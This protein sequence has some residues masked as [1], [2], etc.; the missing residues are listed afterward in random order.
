MVQNV[1]IGLIIVTVIIVIYGNIRKLA[2]VNLV[3]LSGIVVANLNQTAVLTLVLLELAVAVLVRR[4]VEQRVIAVLHRQQVEVRI[5]ANIAIL[6]VHG[7]GQEV[8]MKV[9]NAVVQE[10]KLDYIVLLVHVAAGHQ[11]AIQPI[12]V[13]LALMD[14]PNPLVKELLVTV[15]Q[16]AY[17]TMHLKQA[18]QHVSVQEAIHRLERALLDRQAA[19][20]LVDLVE[21]SVVI[22]LI[23]HAMGQL[24]GQDALLVRIEQHLIVI[25]IYVK[26][27]TQLLHTGTQQPSNM[28]LEQVPVAVIQVMQANIG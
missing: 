23:I 2:V 13:L 16:H 10:I 20:C 26:A 22:V 18:N 3:V 5:I 24:A 1:M 17:L 12:A 19:G 8:I 4:I 11:P 21:T 9:G 6:A 7:H 27:A 14:R 15:V 28:N 25:S